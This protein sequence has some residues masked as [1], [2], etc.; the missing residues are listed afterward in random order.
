MNM[1]LGLAPSAWDIGS[2]FR[3]AN[4][5]DSLD[6][7]TARHFE[8]V[9]LL[10]IALPGIVYITMLLQ[11]TL[12]RCINECNGPKWLTKVFSNVCS[13]LLVAAIVFGLAILIYSKINYHLHLRSQI[14]RNLSEFCQN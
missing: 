13:L 14:R 9:S 12:E 7:D 2:D 6:V 11:E 1:I 4:E 10:F 3:F 5:L 8:K